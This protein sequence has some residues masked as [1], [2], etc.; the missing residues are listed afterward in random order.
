MIACFLRSSKGNE[1][2]FSRL[3][4]GV[5]TR[6]TLRSAP[7]ALFLTLAALFAT[8]SLGCSGKIVKLVPLSDRPFAAPMQ[9]DFLG[10]A[11]ETAKTERLLLD[12]SLRDG[13]PSN[14][15]T[16]V[17]LQRQIDRAPTSD[18]LRSFAELSYTEGV[19]QEKKN[20]SL[21]AEIYI[22][23]ALNSYR[24]LF[25]PAFASGRNPY[26]DEF[27]FVAAHYNRSL[28]R[29]LRLME[30][31]RTEEMPPLRP[32]GEITLTSDDRRWTMRCVRTDGPDNERTNGRT[33]AGL[34]TTG[35]M[36]AAP[37][38][39]RGDEIDHF[40]FVSDYKLL[41]LENRCAQEGIGVPVIAFRKA[42][43]VRPEEKYYPPEH[44]FPMTLFLRPNPKGASPHRGD[45]SPLDG[46][47]AILEFRDPVVS[48]TVSVGRVNAPLAYDLT[49]ALAYQFND[50]KSYLLGT[51]GLTDPEDFAK[52]LPGEGGNGRHLKGL[53][54]IE[55]YAPEKIPVVMIHG[56][57][58]SPLT[59]LE[60]VNALESIPE[61]RENC[62]FWFYFYPSGIPWWVSADDLRQ[63]LR[64]LRKTLDP[65]G[66]N[67]QLQ[68]MVLVGHSM[69]GLIA[70]LQV[71]ESG[72]AVW[73]LVSD[74]PLDDFPEEQR[75]RLRSWFYFEPDQSIR[76]VVTI[77]TPFKGSD[78]ANRF[79]RW[80]A[81]KAITLPKQ[82]EWTAALVGKVGKGKN[83]DENDENAN[84]KSAPQKES[85]L[86]IQNSIDSLAPETPFF[87]L[88]ESLETPSAVAFN[89][90][91][92][93]AETEPF[94]DKIVGDGVVDYRS[95]H[96]DGLESELTVP[97]RHMT[98][99]TDPAS[100]RETARILHEHIYQMKI[101]RLALTS[102]KSL[103]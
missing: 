8:L 13:E 70:R 14:L 40:R 82:V 36:G 5:R 16:L 30:E 42:G 43:T 65:R 58:S 96:L 41:G 103:K 29:L 77:A 19:R 53:Y 55:P 25:D 80:L 94:S 101:E 2:G 61:I 66:E 17:R 7:L 34:N 81:E 73:R 23:S 83:S 75:E 4:V 90:I 57:W 59:W 100:I 1:R 31:Y 88:L 38:G 89:N 37:R 60:M 56:L 39:W 78:S 69:G 51:V 87:S 86:T 48:P 79:T 63:E 72:D 98:V 20:P 10:R 12:Y 9:T 85:L 22:A 21:A 47:E 68:E 45:R 74:R 6:T 92:G 26:S 54:L 91:V 35:T 50:P 28:E 95:A 44:T 32:G 67:A 24:W 27:R 71:A 102:E 3:A 84:P 93:V 11:Q 97:A 99:Q 52:P 64:T 18:L 33:S 46:P 76:R 62:Q 49:L 15:E